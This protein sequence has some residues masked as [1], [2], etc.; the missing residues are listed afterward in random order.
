MSEGGTFLLHN[1]E[2]NLNL[3]WEKFKDLDKILDV[4]LKKCSFL[5]GAM[6]RLEKLQMSREQISNE[7]IMDYKRQ[8]VDEDHKQ[9]LEKVDNKR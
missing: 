1:M 7:F 4:F 8:K 9:H 2:V 6:I 3:A 5:V